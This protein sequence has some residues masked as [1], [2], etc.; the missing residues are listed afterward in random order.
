MYYEGV[1]YHIRK[2]PFPNLASESLLLSNGDGSYVILL[3]SRFPEEVL[4]L[5]LAH[6]LE[7]LKQ[8]HLHQ[9]ERPVTEKE[10]EAEGKPGGFAV[11]Q[12]TRT[13]A[14]PKPEAGCPAYVPVPG[15]DYFSSWGRAMQWV[16]EM[17][18]Q[19]Q[20]GKE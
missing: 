11:P 4:R 10:A 13:T 15:L 20:T 8:D 9:P 17:L 2:L 14:K 12:R 5:R 7:H 6:E 16:Q 3:N 19:E 18:E 1:D